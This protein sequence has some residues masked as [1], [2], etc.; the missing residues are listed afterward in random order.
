MADKYLGREVKERITFKAEGTFQSY[1][2]AQRWCT[3]NG[4]EEGSMCG[5]LPIAIMKGEYDLPWKWKNMSQKQKNN[6]DGVIISNYFR[7]EQCEII[8]FA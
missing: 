6:V 5:H 8:L 2:L 3:E 7:E 4:Y 1:Y